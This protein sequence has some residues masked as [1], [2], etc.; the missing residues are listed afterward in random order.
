VLSSLILVGLYSQSSM[1]NVTIYLQG[2]LSVVW[3]ISGF[4]LLHP[5]A[6]ARKKYADRYA[7]ED[8]WRIP[9][10]CRWCTWWSSSAWWRPAQ[11]CNYS[12]AAP[13]IPGMEPSLWMTW[14]GSMLRAMFV[15]GRH[16]VLSSA[17]A[18]PTKLTKEE[19]AC[20]PGRPRPDQSEPDELEGSLT[21]DR[22]TASRE[23]ADATE[24]DPLST[25]PL[26]GAE[27]MAAAKVIA[28]P[29]YGTPTL[30]FVMIQL[31]EPEKT[32]T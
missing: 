8:F 13:W 28:S 26:S 16:R 14:V 25:G 27:I 1:A 19:L 23:A 3:L 10:A 32:R 4:L 6:I 18:R 5:L 31:A 15:L 21:D 12:F 17:A 20:A 9:G 2:G 22:W 30:K 29:E 24:T 11:A 7:S